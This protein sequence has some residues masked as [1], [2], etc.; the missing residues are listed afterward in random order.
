MEP[1]YQRF[2]PGQDAPTIHDPRECDF[3]ANDPEQ[4]HANLDCEARAWSN[5]YCGPH[6]PDPASY[7]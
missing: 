6:Q 7:H 1:T 5:G 2:G 4:C 3:C